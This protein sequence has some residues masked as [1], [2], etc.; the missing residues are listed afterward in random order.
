MSEAIHLTVGEKILL[1]LLEHQADEEEPVVSQE[2]TQHGIA[3]ALGIRQSHV[4]Y[5]INILEAKGMDLGAKDAGRPG[6]GGRLPGSGAG[7]G[8][9]LT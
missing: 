2:L 9:A 5:D 8:A 6:H 1:Q 7:A 3:S 4:S